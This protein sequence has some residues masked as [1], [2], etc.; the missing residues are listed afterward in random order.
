M[1]EGSPAVSVILPVYNTEKYLPRCLDSLLG[2]TFSDFEILAVDNGSTDGSAAILHKYAQKDSR[3]RVLSSRPGDVGAARNAGLKAARGRYVMFCD[4]DD[5]VTGV[6]RNPVSGRI[7]S[8]DGYGRVQL[9][10]G[11]GTQQRP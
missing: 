8:G 1:K 5:W 2:Q 3:V 4:S 11:S 10:P 7:A 9:H 6:D